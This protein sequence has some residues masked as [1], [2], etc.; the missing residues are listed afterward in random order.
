ML[1]DACFEATER[2]DIWLA[3]PEQRSTYNATILAR[4]DVL[5]AGLD[6]LRGLLDTTSLAS[7]AI[8]TATA[9]DL[10]PLEAQLAAFDQEWREQEQPN[11][12]FSPREFGVW[13]HAAVKILRAMDEHL[14]PLLPELRALAP[15]PPD[16]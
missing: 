13:A 3:D 6:A 9:G 2:L 7:S 5:R 15:K 14:A 8:E 12:D 16:A 1:S 4:A 11:L 10:Q